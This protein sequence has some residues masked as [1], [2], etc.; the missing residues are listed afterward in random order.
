MVPSNPPTYIAYLDGRD[1]LSNVRGQMK[2]PW[3]ARRV[4]A[5]SKNP[6][7][8]S[9]VPYGA[10]RTMKK[11]SRGGA[12]PERAAARVGAGGYTQN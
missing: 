4:F 2:P 8:L 1:Y 12:T 9:L 6:I 10:G 3:C 11:M 5:R 7:L